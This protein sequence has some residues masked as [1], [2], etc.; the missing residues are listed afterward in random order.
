VARGRSPVAHHPAQEV[1]VEAA[2]DLGIW[3]SVEV[4]TSNLL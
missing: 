4:S 3:N 2:Y 1:R